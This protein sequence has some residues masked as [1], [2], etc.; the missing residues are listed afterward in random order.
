LEAFEFCP[1]DIFQFNTAIK[2]RNSLESEIQESL[3]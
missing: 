3:T 2:I 1:L